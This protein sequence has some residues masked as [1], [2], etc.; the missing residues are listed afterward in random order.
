MGGY[1]IPKTNPSVPRSG[2]SG[3]A[4]E[5]DEAASPASSTSNYSGT[6][7]VGKAAE[8]LSPTKEGKALPLL[9]LS[10]SAGSIFQLGI[11]VFSLRSP[12]FLRAFC[13]FLF[14]PLSSVETRRSRSKELAKE[15]SRPM[16]PFFLRIVRDRVSS[17]LVQQGS[18]PVR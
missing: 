1:A 17:H 3:L 2:Q 10:L 13:L 5:R 6:L 16:P 15:R 18:Q 7:P 9:S 11:D 8:H 14:L 4:S 12:Q